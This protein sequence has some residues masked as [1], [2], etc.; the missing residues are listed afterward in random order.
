ML[1]SSDELIAGFNQQVGNEMGASMQ[2]ISIA[3]F[4][5]ASARPTASAAELKPV[6]GAPISGIRNSLPE[7]TTKRT[8]RIA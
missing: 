8:K 7:S 6:L 2:Y 4:S 1:A 5:Q 3:S